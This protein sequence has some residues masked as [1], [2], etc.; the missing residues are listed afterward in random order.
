MAGIDKV[1]EAIQQAEG[2]PD[3]RDLWSAEIGQIN[4]D[5]WDSYLDALLWQPVC[6]PLVLDL[7]GDG[8]ETVGTNAAHPILFDHNADGVKTS[9]G[10]V[11]P[12]DGFL[13]LDRSGN[14]TIDD[15]RELFGDSTPLNTDGSLSATLGV[16]KDGFEA[17]D[18]E[19]T[20][21]DGL[22]S[23]AD[24]RWTRLRIWRDI[25]QDGVSQSGELLSLSSLGIAS[26]RTQSG[27][28]NSVQNNGNIVL[29]RGTYARTDGSQRETGTVGE[30]SNLDFVED[31]FRR[32]FTD[33]LP[34][35]DQTKQL[36]AMRGS[37]RVRDLLEATTIG[38]TAQQ[39]ITPLRSLLI[40][41]PGPIV[42]RSA[43]CSIR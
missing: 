35:D 21:R 39:P 22:V 43:G 19:D 15:G 34:Y 26:I 41:L 28:A 38:A 30:V 5:V 24:A 18:K 14:G 10:W 11:Q 17:L 23:S 4:P 31:T 8:I 7:D 37:G 36:P 25:N 40:S 2:N 3:V 12:D 27:V 33:F 13:V 20:N 9:T 42:P 6:E 1:L 32:Q 29:S 16:A